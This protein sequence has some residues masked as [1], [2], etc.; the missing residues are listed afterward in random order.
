MTMNSGC[1][2]LGKKSSVGARPFPARA[3]GG[4]MGRPHIFHCEMF[5][6][7]RNLTILPLVS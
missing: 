7:C 6:I 5:I 2:F 4:G 1:Y 3:Y